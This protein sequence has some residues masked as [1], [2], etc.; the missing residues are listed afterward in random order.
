[1]RDI[2]EKKGR[3]E[4][5]QTRVGV[6]VLTLGLA[7]YRLTF[8][9][10]LAKRL[11]QH[12]K[13][14]ILQRS[15][16][17]DS[18]K[19]KKKENEEDNISIVSVSKERVLIQKRNEKTLRRG[20]FQT[21]PTFRQM[22]EIIRA[23]P[24]VIITVEQSVFCWPA[25]LYCLWKRIPLLLETDMGPQGRKSLPIY[26]RINQ[27]IYQKLSTLVLA[28]TKDAA[29]QNPKAHFVPHAVD[30]GSIRGKPVLLAFFFSEC[31]D[32]CPM[33]M[34]NLK[35]VY[36]GLEKRSD[37]HFIG[38]SVDP[39]RDTPM[40]LSSY[41]NQ[42][43]SSQKDRRNWRL[44]TGTRPVIESVA[45]GTFAVDAF[46]DSKQARIVHTEKIFLMDQN[47]FVRKIMNGTKASLLHEIKLAL[48]ELAPERNVGGAT[49]HSPSKIAAS[50]G[51]IVSR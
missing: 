30:S 21:P 10:H 33:L 22:V 23:H 17:T 16:A 18:Y 40:K 19:W 26:K 44:L 27:F 50:P 42:L 13:I 28:K 34:R 31:P 39:E 51:A 15:G 3:Q 48:D 11:K 38:I 7:P 32:F 5:K 24:Q 2:A 29:Y 47:G 1:L 14:L 45:K 37:I 9:R 36:G 41:L 35:A 4:K 20:V 25:L 12:G 49:P 43:F 6:L 46:S 8:C